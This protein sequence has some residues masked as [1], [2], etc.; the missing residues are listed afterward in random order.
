MSE[1][2]NS[3]LMTKKA[4]AEG[5]REE[6]WGQML[7]A[8]SWEPPPPEAPATPEATPG[9]QKPAT[10]GQ[11]TSSFR[12]LLTEVWEATKALPETAATLATGTMAWPIS[13]VGG[14]G[15]TIAKG[16]E[17]G[18]E[19]EQFL[20][21]HY[22]YQPKS[23]AA[24][25]QLEPIGKAMETIMKP[26]EW[27]G[28]VYG[29]LTGSEAGQYFITKTGEVATLF[30]LPKVGKTA[31]KA[32]VKPK[33]W[34]GGI[35]AADIQKAKVQ[36]L[37]ER[38]VAQVDEALKKMPPE[39]MATVQEAGKSVSPADLA[40]ILEDRAKSIEVSKLQKETGKTIKLYRGEGEPIGDYFEPEQFRG[41]WW[42]KDSTIAERY[43]KVSAIDFPKENIEKYR[44]INNPKAT[45]YSF[46]PHEEFIIPTELTKEKKP[47]ESPKSSAEVS[48]LRESAAALKDLA[49]EADQA[50][51]EPV[52]VPEAI[53]PKPFRNIPEGAQ[54]A[55]E[56]EGKIYTGRTHFEIVEQNNL[57]PGSV[58]SGYVT[59]EGKFYA[60]GRP[61]MPEI[62]IAELGKVGEKIEIGDWIK[63]GTLRGQ[64]TGEGKIGKNVEAWKVDRGGGREEIVPKGAADLWHKGEQNLRSFPEIARD[65]KTVMELNEKGEIGNLGSL[66]PEKQ[67]AYTRLK[68]D[69]L[70][71]S[72]N[73]RRAGKSIENYLGDLGIDKDLIAYMVRE[74]QAAQKKQEGATAT[75]PEPVPAEVRINLDRILADSAVR[76]IVAEMDAEIGATPAMEAHRTVKKHGI[77]ATQAEKITLKELL[78]TPARTEDLAPRLLALRDE[79]NRAATRVQ[80]LR[81]WAKSGDVAA[82]EKVLPMSLLAG[83]LIRRQEIASR[84]IARALEAHKILS[85]EGRARVDLGGLADLAEAYRNAKNINPDIFMERLDALIEP[86]QQKTFFRHLA[87][88]Y[89]KDTDIFNFVWINGL[90]SGPPTHVVNFASSS[91]TFLGS[92]GERYASA[93]IAQVGRLWKHDPGVAWGE[94][95]QML[96]GAVDGF[97]DALRASKKSWMENKPQFG[98][99]KVEYET[100][101]LSREALGTTG[102][103]GQSLE[104]MGDIIGGPGR[105][106]LT[107]DE[108]WKGINYRGE[109]RARAFRE[110]KR[111]G[112][113]GNAFEERLNYII[114]HPEEF[115][116]IHQAA[117][118]FANYQTFNSELGQIGQ[119]VMKIANATPVTRLLLPFVRTP[120]NILKYT[121]ERVP[122]LNL[123]SSRFWADIAKGG[124]ESELAMGKM[125]MG[126]MVVASIIELA[127]S[128]LITGSGPTDK[129][130]KKVWMEDGRQPYSV[131]VGDKWIAYDRMDPWGNVVGIAAD[132]TNMTNDLDLETSY[133]VFSAAALSLSNLMVN[134]TYLK[135][136]GD[137]ITAIRSPDRGAEN[138]V[139]QWSR[140]LTPT[141]FRTVNRAFF[142][143]VVREVNSISDAM[144]AGIPGLSEDL[145]PKRGFWGQPVIPEGSL[146][147]DLLSPYRVTTEKKDLVNEEI[148][149]NRM[150]LSM[151][152]KVLGGYKPSENPLVME[153]NSWGVKLSPQQ[154]DRFVELSRAE[155]IIAG[156]N[157]KEAIEDL[158]NTASYQRQSDGPEGG[159]ALLIREVLGKYQEAA[160][161]RLRDEFPELGQKIDDRRKQRLEGLRPTQTPAFQ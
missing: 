82:R 147:P 98:Q 131:K 90:L 126:V 94:G 159:K 155:P 13:I 48:A 7:K 121:W 135:G 71:I 92:I 123:V 68:K 117:R 148:L 31:K 26:A 62:S 55:V 56:S 104:F 61:G 79:V 70:T 116:G 30:M 66:P 153:K 102:A 50:G 69:F 34:E 96:Y 15:G 64:I 80:E 24:Q 129:K 108:F 37:S 20:Q 100:N 65:L 145:P 113:T 52:I 43:G 1:L 120:G 46:Q 23:K 8:N 22:T 127:D 45:E 109:L 122:G 28:E 136:I 81:E 40:Q 114:E 10:E 4:Q 25:T 97:M 140:S 11:Q 132:L 112:L 138:Y 12:N 86:A 111:E 47:Y 67:A 84:N 107:A 9:Q 91:A 33:P 95:G 16:P 101:P 17:W 77:T 19:F 110:A 60:E 142:D 99:K 128:G 29:K 160:K 35:K 53:S 74:S 39:E 134:K 42:T 161:L 2:D 152:P 59:K 157:A 41:M 6:G 51:V 144:R 75:P 3:F 143:D 73:A 78:E 49:K 133:Q 115:E 154:Y 156:K 150:S 106:L 151:P 72:Q 27:V 124:A 125:A 118:D 63:T 58:R 88:G 119:G 54:I 93:G 137:F 141:I 139:R 76:D 103:F 83:E 5:Q 158:I 44:V 146:G 149:N 57:D 32:V 130:L 38:Y 89:K 105:A 14:I 36:E 21:E 18:K 85:E 87:E